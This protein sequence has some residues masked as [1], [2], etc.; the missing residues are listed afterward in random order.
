MYG[1]L[2]RGAADISPRYGS[3]HVLIPGPQWHATERRAWDKSD[4]DASESEGQKE[5]QLVGR[6]GAMIA[7]H[8]ALAG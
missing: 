1:A 5:C 8:G 7:G 2:Q 4:S 3:L 6:I